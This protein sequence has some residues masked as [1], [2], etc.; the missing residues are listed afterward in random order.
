M[1]FVTS[2]LWT[3]TASLRIE[4]RPAECRSLHLPQI[5][6]LNLPKHGKAS[7]QCPS[8]PLPAGRVFWAHADDDKIY[9]PNWAGRLI[10]AAQKQLDCA[11]VEERSDLKHI[12][13]YD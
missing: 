2:V 7:L 8:P 10:N 9:D 4:T 12:S 1:F 3:S 5:L 11:I 6:S 13:I